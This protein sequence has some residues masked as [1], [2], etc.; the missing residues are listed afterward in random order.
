M[1]RQQK[2]FAVIPAKILANKRRAD[3]VDSLFSGAITADGLFYSHC[4]IKDVSTTG[5]RITMSDDVELPDVFEIKVATIDNPMR[6]RVAWR[7][8]C[9]MGVHSVEVDEANSEAATA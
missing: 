1:Q 7:R 3:R 4:V 5:M 8:G 9:D 6:V 2:Q